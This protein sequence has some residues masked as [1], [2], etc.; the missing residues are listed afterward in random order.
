MEKE[1]DIN[2]R[3]IVLKSLTVEEGVEDAFGLADESTQ[4]KAIKNL[5]AKTLKKSGLDISGFELRDFIPLS[6]AVSELNGL[7]DADK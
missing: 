3:T 6:Q 1:F 2:G 4:A 7:N 5:V